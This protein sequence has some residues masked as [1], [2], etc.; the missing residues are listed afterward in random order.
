ML[1]FYGRFVSMPSKCLRIH[2]K[3][4]NYYVRHACRFYDL[5]PSKSKSKSVTAI[6]RW[7]WS[8]CFKMIIWHNPKWIFLRT[9]LYAEVHKS[10]QCIIRLFLVILLFRLESF[11]FSWSLFRWRSILIRVFVDIELSTKKPILIDLKNKTIKN[12]LSVSKY[13]WILVCCCFCGCSI[14]IA[15]SIDR[16]QALLSCSKNNIDLRFYRNLCQW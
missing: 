15:H 6:F 4:M 16:C 14:V 11:F 8:R 2:N 10:G 5:Q 7:L 1:I 3:Y 12:L 9:C 13:H